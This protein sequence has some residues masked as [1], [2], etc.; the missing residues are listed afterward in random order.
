MKVKKFSAGFLMSL[1]A[2]FS[3]TLLL[4]ALAALP[5][6][7]AHKN[8]APDF[9]LC[10]D[11]A[12]ALA[13]SGAFSSGSLQDSLNGMHDL[14][15]MCFSAGS[16]S[17]AG[18]S[19]AAPGEKISISIPA[20]DGTALEEATVFCWRAAGWAVNGGRPSSESEPMFHEVSTQGDIYVVGTEAEQV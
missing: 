4:I 11:A 8:P 3:L 19:L 6:F 20:F 15:G 17:S 5:A 12:L 7:Q 18:C 1:E 2:A 13:K 10:S 14:S 16:S 9:F